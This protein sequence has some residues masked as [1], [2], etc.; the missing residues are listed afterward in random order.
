MLLC[1]CTNYQ[2][3]R[4]SGRGSFSTTKSRIRDHKRGM[5]SPWRLDGAPRRPNAHL[6]P[7]SIPPLLYF[8]SLTECGRMGLGVSCACLTCQFMVLF[9]P[10]ATT[11]APHWTP[12]SSQPPSILSLSTHMGLIYHLRRQSAR[13][14]VSV[15]V[16]SSAPLP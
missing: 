1:Y 12:P 6:P 8:S 5:F 3:T 14:H 11:S 13:Q 2:N 9:M 7:P 4:T 10:T 15:S 16:W